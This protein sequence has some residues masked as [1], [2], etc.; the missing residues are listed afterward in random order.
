M[1]L[2]SPQT[3]RVLN[4]DLNKASKHYYTDLA[5]YIIEGAKNYEYVRIG[6]VLDQPE[7]DKGVCRNFNNATHYI[8]DE[9]IGAP[10]AD[11][12]DFPLKKH[13]EFWNKG[14][15]ACI[16]G[17]VYR[18]DDKGQPINP[19]L[20]TGV[21]GLGINGVYGPSHVVDVGLLDVKPDRSG[22]LALYA[23][24][25]M[26]GP[27]PAFCGGFT[28]YNKKNKNGF[29]VEKDIWVLN[30]C[31]EFFEEMVSGSIH[32]IEPYASQLDLE[33]QAALTSR[34]Q[35]RNGEGLS[36]EE[37]AK[38]KEQ[39]KTELK[40]KQVKENDVGFLQRTYTVFSQGKECYRG[41]VRSSTRN[42]DTSWMETYLSWMF[43]NQATWDYIKG[44][45]PVFDYKLA[46]GDDAD[47]VVA[48]KIDK[49]LLEKATGSHGMMFLLMAASY[50]LDEQKKGHII[51]GAVLKQVEDVAKY[52]G[53]FRTEVSPKNKFQRHLKLL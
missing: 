50:V 21:S 44:T 9:V 11:D 6:Q 22:D 45:K 13:N 49:N 29:I 26:K 10:W 39:V 34:V 18:L 23:H 7:Y 8:A 48:H 5:R 53:G 35:K 51:D 15:R 46:A 37:E 33:Y 25:I 43:L 14:R 52:A 42:T 27:R 4:D 20:K 31:K 3:M 17:D 38:L 40:F 12:F 30:Q 32:L 24:G 19:Y 2:L 16:A 28:E 47:D 36:K 1:T 41:P